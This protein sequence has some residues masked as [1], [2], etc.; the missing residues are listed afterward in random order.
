[1]GDKY[2]P[3]RMTFEDLDL[4]DME[5]VDEWLNHA[6]TKA[7][8]EDLRRA[9][10]REPAAHQREMISRSLAADEERLRELDE[11]LTTREYEPEAR[12]ALEQLRAALDGVV[13]AARLRLIE[14]DDE[15]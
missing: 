14:L 8:H 13:T 15:E 3:D 11:A 1:M 10:R 12:A 7:L 6:V 9:F 4:T 5:A 2:D